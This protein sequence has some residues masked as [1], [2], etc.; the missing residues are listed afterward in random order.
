MDDEAT[1]QEFRGVLSRIWN[2]DVT[3]EG[4][5]E[6]EKTLAI[7]FQALVNVWDQY[8]FSTTHD[9]H[10]IFPL[11]KATFLTVLNTKLVDNSLETRIKHPS[12]RFKD[13]TI[14]KLAAV[15]N[16]A[17]E[18]AGQATYNGML[19]VTETRNTVTGVADLLSKLVVMLNGELRNRPP[20]EPDYGARM[21]EVEY[22]RG[23]RDAF[24]G[25][26]EALRHLVPGNN[27]E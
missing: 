13:V 15:L 2:A 17:M 27:I 26:I 4:S 6:D 14:P 11:I 20:P 18:R 9:I 22:W 19:G 5:I 21:A 3:E 16:R 24:N 1:T 7:A 25:E 23:M 10:R 12:Q 8:D